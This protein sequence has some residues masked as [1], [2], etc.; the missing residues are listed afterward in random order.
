M[1]KENK[2]EGLKVGF[3]VA[4]VLILLGILVAG[5]LIIIKKFKDTKPLPDWGEKYYDYLKEFKTSS[6]TKKLLSENKVVMQDEYQGTFYT[7]DK[8]QAPA[9]ILEYTPTPTSPA[10]TPADG[11]DN[12]NVTPV[13]PSDPDVVTPEPVEQTPEPVEPTPVVSKNYIVI[14]VLVNG[15]IKEY[16]FEANS[17]SVELLYNIEEKEY[18]YYLI[19][20]EDDSTHFI[21]VNDYIKFLTDANFTYN[22]IVIKDGETVELDGETVLKIDITFF[23][24]ENVKGIYFKFN[25]NNIKELEASMGTYYD[26]M[27]DQYKKLIDDKKNGLE[28]YIDNYFYIIIEIYGDDWGEDPI[29]E[30]PADPEPEPTPTPTPEPEPTPVCEYDYLTYIYDGCYD[31]GQLVTPG[32]CDYGY[33]EQNGVCFSFECD[34]NPE[35]GIDPNCKDQYPVPGPNECAPGLSLHE[36]YCFR[37]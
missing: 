13:N 7:Y 14:L 25:P 21:K 36:G 15:E 8:K 30:D 28:N 6:K 26:N 18:Y 32:G 24:P 12:G 10:S 34:G 9:M 29:P 22:E 23:E 17:L 4:V 35:D 19:Y 3:V 20:R 27:D 11:G 1:E 2:K 31:L 16:I 33:Y 5:T 37:H